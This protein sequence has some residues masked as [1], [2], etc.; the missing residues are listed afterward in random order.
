MPPYLLD[1]YVHTD[2]Q[3]FRQMIKIVGKQTIENFMYSL[4]C[5]L[6]ALI[7]V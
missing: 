5:K 4:S 3:A 6:L 2:K 7:L 1:A